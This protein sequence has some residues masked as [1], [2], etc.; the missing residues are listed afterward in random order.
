MQ[1]EKGAISLSAIPETMLF[2]L[3][4]RASEAMRP[5]S[6]FKDPL[7]VHIYKSLDFDFIGHFGTP[8][9]GGV[10]T[11]A[12]QFDRIISGWLKEH[13]E[14]LVVSLGEGLETQ[15]ERVDNGKMRWLSIDLPEAMQ[16]RERFLKPTARFK[17]LAASAFDPAWMDGLEAS[18]GLFVVA[19]GLFMYFEEGQVRPLVTEIFRRFPQSCLLFDFLSKSFVRRTKKGSGSR[20]NTACPSWAGARAPKR[21]IS[22]CTSGFQIISPPSLATTTFS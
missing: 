16:I 15:R 21:S 4:N 11:R 1:D 13:P 5:D 19:Q 14:G 12:A 22:S 7:A 6:T 17:H 9:R 20:P 10:A 18:K 2:T 8:P 3:Y